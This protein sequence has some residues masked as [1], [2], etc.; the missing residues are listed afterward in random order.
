MKNKI[1]TPLIIFLSV[2][3]LILLFFLLSKDREFTIEKTSNSEDALISKLKEL[4]ILPEDE[5]PTIAT[6]SDPEQLKNQAFFVK[7]KKGDK[8]IIY[9]KARKAILYDPEANKIVEVAPINL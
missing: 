5:K 9:A 6:V 1:K 8:V 3:A 7:A 2:I 4:I